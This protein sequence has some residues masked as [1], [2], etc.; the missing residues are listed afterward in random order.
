MVCRWT[1]R[2]AYPGQRE[3]PYDRAAR[4]ANRIRDK[5][6]WE[7]GISNGEGLK[8]K[9]MHWCSFRKLAAEHDEHAAKS[10]LMMALRF[11]F[12]L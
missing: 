8:P 6:G 10:F 2:L 11:G 1:E 7:S 5:L 4:H 3:T 9:G 12:E